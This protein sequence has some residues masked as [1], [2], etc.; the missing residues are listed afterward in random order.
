M[1]TQD[2]RN[3]AHTLG[4][5]DPVL[6]TCLEPL[7]LPGVLKSHAH[8]SRCRRHPTA[9]GP[10]PSSPVIFCGHMGHI[11]CL[12]LDQNNRSQTGDTSQQGREPWLALLLHTMPVEFILQSTWGWL[13]AAKGGLL[14][15][16][17]HT[18][19]ALTAKVSLGW[20]LDREADRWTMSRSWVGG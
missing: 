16:S 3:R 20:I 14:Q 1:A 8:S 9:W 19:C 7:F 18:Q 6:I 2:T 10:H 15:A 12:A 4:S 11:H 17:H 5:N 13:T